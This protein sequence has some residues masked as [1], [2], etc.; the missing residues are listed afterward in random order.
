MGRACCSS[1]VAGGIPSGPTRDD[2]DPK[3]KDEVLRQSSRIAV[4]V[5]ICPPTDIRKWVSDPPPLVK[6]STALMKPLTFDP[7]LAGDYSPVLHATAKTPPTLLIHG[8]K[9]ELVT[10]EHSNTMLAALE[11]AKVKSKLLVIEGGE[12]TFTA[13]H[14]LTVVP[15]FVEWFDTH[16]GAAKGGCVSTFCSTA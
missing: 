5:A 3:A 11:K 15:A 7:K 9:D 12:H 4:A 10:I 13:K 14:N 1:R 2:G 16:L 6:A 8:N